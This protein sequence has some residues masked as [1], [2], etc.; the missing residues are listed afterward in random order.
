MTIIIARSRVQFLSLQPRKWFH[1]QGSSIQFAATA[2]RSTKTLQTA[3]RETNILLSPPCWI[4]WH[5]YFGSFRYPILSRCW[6][7]LFKANW[8]VLS[9]FKQVQSIK[10]SH[11]FITFFLLVHENWKIECLRFF[12]V[13]PSLKSDAV[14]PSSLHSSL[15][16]NKM[17]ILL[18]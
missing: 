11:Y 15:N 14:S 3:P 4:S 8:L 1:L 17:D 9:N 16:V 12:G 6:E 7:M 5:E 13:P 10:L 18:K 2:N